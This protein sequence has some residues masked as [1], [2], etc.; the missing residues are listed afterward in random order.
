MCVLLHNP[1]FFDD[2]EGLN[3][4]NLD[5]FEPFWASLVGRIWD[6]GLPEW[7]KMVIRELSVY[8]FLVQTKKMSLILLFIFIS[9]SLFETCYDL[10]FI[11]LF[12]VIIPLFL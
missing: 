8:F 3:W 10:F 1:T 4:G 6:F 9:I 5:H 11:S 12:S 2:L 7:T